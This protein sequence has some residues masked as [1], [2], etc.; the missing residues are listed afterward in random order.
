MLGAN[1]AEAGGHVV[2]LSDQLKHRFFSVREYGK[3]SMQKLLERSQA[4]QGRIL[5]LVAYDLRRHQGIERIPIGSVDRGDEAPD[6]RLV[7]IEHRRQ[8]SAEP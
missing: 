8:P 7:M 1:K 2:V 3:L 4:S 6:Q 5:A